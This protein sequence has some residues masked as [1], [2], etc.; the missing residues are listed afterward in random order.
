MTPQVDTFFSSGAHDRGA[1][2]AA[3]VALIHSLDASPVVWQFAVILFYF[4]EFIQLLIFILSPRWGWNINFK[5]V[6][7]KWFRRFQ[8]RNP[9]ALTGRV[10]CEA[11]KR[12]GEV[13]G[14]SPAGEQTARAPPS[15]ALSP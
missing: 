6:F 10:T 12:V 13:V 8:A 14:L 11:S 4:I 7:W 15:P 3:H 2:L 1:R 9:G 5:N